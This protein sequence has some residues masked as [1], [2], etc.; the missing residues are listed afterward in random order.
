MW[1]GGIPHC[2]W[3]VDCLPQVDVVCRRAVDETFGGARRKAWK[4]GGVEE[5]V[6]GKRGGGG[7]VHIIFSRLCPSLQGVRHWTP[8]QCHQKAERC[9][10][11]GAGTGTVLSISRRVTVIV[12][13]AVAI[14]ALCR[15]RTHSLSMSLSLLLPLGSGKFIFRGG[16]FEPLKIKGV[17]LEKG[18]S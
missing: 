6:R 18:F 2:L 5:G 10:G 15:A 1:R 8:R 9:R 12:A 13:V 17:F 7:L 14:S 3:S 11:A 16:P 4:C